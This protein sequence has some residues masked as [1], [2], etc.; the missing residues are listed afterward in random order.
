MK[1]VTKREGRQAEGRSQE[2]GAEAKYS[3][4]EGEGKAKT[5]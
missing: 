1:Q 3:E 4:G 5:K 2:T